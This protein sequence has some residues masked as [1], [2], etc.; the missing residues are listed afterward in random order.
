M[1]SQTFSQPF[2]LFDQLHLPWVD[3]EYP[4]SAYYAYGGPNLSE[5]VGFLV[6]GWQLR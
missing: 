1:N 3:S 4:F 5:K 2:P 6:S